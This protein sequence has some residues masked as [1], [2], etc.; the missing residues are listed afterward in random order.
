IALS[1]RRLC[2]RDLRGHRE[3]QEGSNRG[4]RG[5]RSGPGRLRR[6]V[7]GA[8]FLPQYQL[9]ARA[10]ADPR[11]AGGRR[12]PMTRQ[13]VIDVGTNSVKFHVA[14]RRPDGTWVP[15]LDRAEVTRLGEGIRE[16]GEIAP[17]AITRTAE[18]I[19][20]MAAEAARLGADGVTA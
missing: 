1:H 17:A 8:R 4:R 3:R 10:E 18:A 16:H 6:P 20:G 13:A 5:R 12:T 2:R 15:V 19:A 7:R 11:L 14:D 9:S